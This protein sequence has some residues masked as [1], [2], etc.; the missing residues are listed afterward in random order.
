MSAERA[1]TAIPDAEN[2]DALDGD[3]AEAT[4]DEERLAVGLRHLRD[5]LE[6]NQVEEARRFV[7]ELEAR[8]PD[9]ERVR[10]YAHVL[11]PPTSRSRPDVSARSREQEWNWLKEHGHEYPGC[12]LA[13]YGDRLIAADPDLQVVMAKT[14]ET[15]G[16][17]GALIHQQ[18]GTPR[19]T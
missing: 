5:L 14:R 10:H 7:K 1:K 19:S 17:E 8:W 9:A 13:I 15:L 11:A 2:G 16:E 12:W 4:S 18:P 6:W 3:A